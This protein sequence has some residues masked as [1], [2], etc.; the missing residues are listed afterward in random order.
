[1]WNRSIPLGIS[2]IIFNNKMET[3]YRYLHN[4]MYTIEGTYLF[5]V[6]NGDFARR[7]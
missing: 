7:E 5:N 4:L 6:E 1:M 2:G 3:S